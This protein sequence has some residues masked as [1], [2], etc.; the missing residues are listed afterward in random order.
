MGKPKVRI[1]T[2][3]RLPSYSLYCNI[4]LQIGTQRVSESPVRQA[5]SHLVSASFFQQ[6][7]YLEQEDEV[8]EEWLG[9]LKKCSWSP[10]TQV[11][12]I[13]ASLKDAMTTADFDKFR[14]FSLCLREG[15][16]KIANMKLHSTSLLSL[17]S[18]LDASPW[19]DSAKLSSSLG[20]CTESFVEIL[21]G[22]NDC[23]AV[24]EECVAWISPCKVVTAV[25]WPSLKGDICTQPQ[26]I[27]S[28]TTIVANC[29]D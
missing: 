17:F 25:V 11:E 3:K 9:G 12:A 24:D 22:L 20:Q 10:Q 4:P 1:C 27:G 15:G 2:Y 14:G 13:Y 7:Y 19:R 29:L 8:G 6:F 26:D 21:P 5:V 18:H 28:H 16:G 23:C